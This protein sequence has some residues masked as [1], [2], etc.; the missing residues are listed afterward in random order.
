MSQ[1][2]HKYPVDRTSRN[3]S[4]SGTTAAAATANQQSS[5][6]QSSDE[7]TSH[8]LLGCA[9]PMAMSPSRSLC[10]AAT[11][12]SSSL[13]AFMICTAR[14][15]PICK[16]FWPSSEYCIRVRIATLYRSGSTLERGNAGLG[17]N[18]C[19]TGDRGDDVRSPTVGLVGV[20]EG[21]RS[22]ASS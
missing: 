16:I 22:L 19:G 1:V 11:M 20:R 15:D 9:S 5:I 21:L 10:L 12:P 13:V 4:P 18:V 8:E 2:L 3:R 6:S 14:W 17:G 7:T